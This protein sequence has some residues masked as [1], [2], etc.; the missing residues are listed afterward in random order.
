VK[1]IING[2]TTL[3][4]GSHYEVTNGVATKYYTST[5]LSAGFAG[6]TRIAMRTG[7]A[8]SYLLSDHLGLT[9][10]TTDSAGNKLFEQRYR[11]ASLWDKPCPLRFT[12]GVLREDETRFPTP[13]TGTKSNKDCDKRLYPFS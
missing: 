7:N 12:S 1:S 5:S 2:E 3:F 8:V 10:I 11:E 4:V 9:S 6:A 13:N